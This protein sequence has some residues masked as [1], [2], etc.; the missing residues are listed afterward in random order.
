M[1]T[2]SQRALS[3]RF[4]GV[5]PSPGGPF[6][7]LEVSQSGHG[8]VLTDC[9]DRAGCRFVDVVERGDHL[10]VTGRIEDV[11]VSDLESP[12]QWFRGSYRT[13]DG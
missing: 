3:D 12:L 10:L 5:R 1:P 2:P 13:L 7:E 9:P 8:P 4:A 6:A 11:A